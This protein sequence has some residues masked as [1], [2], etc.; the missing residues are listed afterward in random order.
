MLRAVRNTEAGT[1][2]SGGDD[3]SANSDVK[4][5]GT[6][7]EVEIS[8][9]RGEAAVAGSDDKLQEI[10]APQVTSSISTAGGALR[11]LSGNVVKSTDDALRSSDSRQPNEVSTTRPAADGSNPASSPV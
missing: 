11:P 7:N 10:E 2:V 1:V 4:M 9:Q 3:E 8:L 6:D 5:T